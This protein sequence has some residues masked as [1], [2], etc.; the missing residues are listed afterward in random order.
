MG[1]TF[2]EIN[3]QQL[4]QISFAAG[5]Q[6]LCCVSFQHMAGLKLR[7]AF[8]AV[9]PSLKSFEVAKSVLIAMDQ[10][11]NG[12]AEAFDV[13]ID[14]HGMSLFQKQVLE[15]TKSIP[16]GS[17]L[18]YGDIARKLKKPGAAR[19]VGSA[20]GSNPMPI[21]IPC[22]RV[23]GSE[24]KLRGYSGGLDRKKVLLDLEGHRIEGDRVIP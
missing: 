18:S 5:D 16:Y 10:Y 4:R 13:E 11:F 22:H 21:V 23:V 17:L 20:L 15:I 12:D 3:H 19:S 9:E 14:W 6:G 7:P 1:F 2:A 24:G 8:R